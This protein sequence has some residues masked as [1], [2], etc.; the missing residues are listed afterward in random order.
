MY[1]DM[2]VRDYRRYATLRV[3]AI[4]HAL[5]GI[6]REKVRLHACWGSFTARTATT[7]PRGHHRHHLPRA[8]FQLLD[9]SLQPLPRARMAVF[10]KV[11]LP[12]GAVLIPGVVGHATD[13]IEHPEL[14]AERLAKYANLVGREN[15]MGGTD[16]GLG[17]AW[18][19]RI[20]WAKLEALA[21]GARIASR[22]LWTRSANPRR[23]V[24]GAQEEVDTSGRA[25]RFEAVRVRPPL[26]SQQLFL[27]RP[28][29][30][31]RP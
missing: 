6:P 17:P 13:F 28:G 30:R 2:S 29:T 12:E 22:R 21:K 14:V 31:G 23:S 1:P 8:R 4:N 5:R 16:C 3:D 15:V 24:R 26:L 20:A 25:G 10:E 11:K 27:V 18:G 19:T 9:R 7:S